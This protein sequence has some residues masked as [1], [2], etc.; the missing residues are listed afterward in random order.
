MKR[1]KVVFYSLL[2]AIVAGHA[3]AGIRVGNLSR[4]YAGTYKNVVGLEQQYYNSVADTT[5]DVA[6]DVSLPVPVANQDLADKIR[7]GTDENTNLETLNNCAMIYPDGEFVWDKPT[8]GRGAGGSATCVAVVEIRAIGANGNAE[9]RTVARGKLAAGDIVNCNIS[10]FPTATYLPDIT[11]VTF[12]ADNPPTREDV[13]RVLN[14]EQKNKA[15]LKIAAATVVAGIAGNMVGK[16]E[17]GS[18]S[19]FGTNE[20]KLKSTAAGAAIGAALMTAS[21]YSGKVAGDVI[22]HT[23]VNAAAGGI[24]GNM[25]ASGDAVLRVEKCVDGGVETT[26]LWGNLQKTDSN[27]PTDKKYYYSPDKGDG[28]I[29]CN[30]DNK[31]CKY[32][33]TLVFKHI[34]DASGKKFTLADFVGKESRVVLTGTTSYTLNE[35]DPNNKEMR[36]TSGSGAYYRAT[37]AKRA[38]APSAAVIVGFKDSAFG[39]KAKD[40]Y[41][42]RSANG[43]SARIC[44]RDSRGNPYNCGGEAKA[45]NQEGASA[46]KKTTYDIN[47]FNPIKLEADDGGV[48][49]FSNKARLGST[50][51]GAGVGGALGGFS[52]YQGAQS[53]IEDRFVQATREYND[54]LEKFYCGTGRKFLSFYNDEVLIPTMK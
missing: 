29:V 31:E 2:G 35:D 5:P 40:W 37:V 25:M 51:K 4:N 43:S 52:G 50:L 17:I 32:D 46:D 44:L 41:N 8:I 20:E 9:Y 54:S 18:D 1:N 10:D 33:G 42:W 26:C 39:I 22:L 19:L 3:F 6:V 24:V 34:D 48:V 47:D 16:S 7:N 27:V 13:I 12:P 14:E 23:G 49:D 30:T 21:T 38:G 53:D 11:Q 36:E 28:I 45:E 15:G